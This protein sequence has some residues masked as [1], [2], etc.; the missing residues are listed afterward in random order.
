MKAQNDRMTQVLTPKA[1]YIVAQGREQSERT[2]GWKH[3]RN[4]TL[5]GLYN[6][7]LPRVARLR[8]L[9]WATL[10]NP[11]GVL[12]LRHVFL[13]EEFCPA[14]HTRTIDSGI[15]RKNK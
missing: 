1:L 15:S 13:L 10:D 11:F 5:I 2:L 7:R 3:E 14:R 4:S 8:R 9:P 6:Q 12:A